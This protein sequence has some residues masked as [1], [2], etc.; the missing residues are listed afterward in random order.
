MPKRSRGIVHVRPFERRFEW[1]RHLEANRWND[2]AVGHTRADRMDRDTQAVRRLD[3]FS[4]AH[5]PDFESA[6]RHP[7]QLR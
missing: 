7:G 2:D 3:G 1:A 4:H 6:D 5:N